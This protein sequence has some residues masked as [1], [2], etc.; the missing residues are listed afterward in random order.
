MKKTILLLGL[1][2]ATSVR[3]GDAASEGFM[4]GDVP[5][6]HAAD[7]SAP[8]VS[9]K[10]L[11]ESERFWP[12]QTA[13]TRAWQSLPTGSVGVLIRVESADTAR[14]DFGRDGRWQVPVGATDLLERA[15]AIRLGQSEKAAPN[16]LWAIGPRLM[17][18]RFPEVRAFPFR[19]AAKS[20]LFLCVF[21]DPW[22]KEFGTLVTALA[23]LRDR[24]GVLTV[25]F[26]QGRRPDSQVSGQLRAM[27]WTPPFVYQHLSEPYSHSLLGDGT[28]LPAV[29]LQTAE[30]RILYEGRFDSD[31]VGK[32]EAALGAHPATG[33]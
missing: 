18:P 25:L 15:N 10:N 17:D 30:G 13:L 12:Y 7:T 11:V 3:A 2:L 19:E 29:Q 6:Y 4:T 23:P 32:L 24:P 8:A 27:K 20:H 14:I 16:L 31:V 33:E 9:A 5:E 22:R 1:T 26:P 28:P 21:A